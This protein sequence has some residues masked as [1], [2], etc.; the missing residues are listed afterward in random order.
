MILRRAPC[1]WFREAFLLGSTIC[2]D[3]LDERSNRRGDRARDRARARAR[4]RAGHAR[5]RR[6]VPLARGDARPRV[7]RAPTR[8]SAD[9]T[10]HA[11]GATSSPASSSS[12]RYIAH[13]SPLKKLRAADLVKRF[14][15]IETDG[16]PETLQQLADLDDRDAG[17]P[18]AS[19]AVPSPPTPGLAAIFLT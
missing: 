17:D 11:A 4:A 19:V 13:D 16:V 12:R 1:V 9:P 7:P 15:D 14:E 3:G 2:D 5:E 8:V 10:P 18:S 6:R